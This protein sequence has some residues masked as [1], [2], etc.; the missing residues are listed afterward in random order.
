M[1]VIRENV[2]ALNAVLKVQIAPE[3][4]LGKVEK[5]LEDYR[6]RANIPGFRK[7]KV[8]MGLVKKQYGKGVLAEELNKTVNEALYNYL[9]AEK[10]EILGNP[11][12]KYDA[13]V[14]G[15]WDNP[16]DFEFQY[17]IGLTPEF[18]IKLSGRNKFD[19]VKVKTD[20][21]LVD[22]QI[23][24]LRRRYGKLIAGEEVTGTE[25][26]LGQ[27]VELDENG[28]IKEGG[29]MNSSTV[30]IEF[31]EDKATLKELKGKKVGDK[32][33][34]DPAKLAKGEADLAAMLGVTKE[35]LPNL[36][37]KFQFTINEI[38]K[39]EMA[40]LNQELFDKLFGEGEV[41]SE[42]EMRERISNDMNGMFDGDSDRLFTRKVYDHLIEKTEMALPDEFLKRWI[43]MSNQKEITDEQIEAEYDEYAKGLR[44][45]LIQGKLFKDNEVKINPD[46]AL[47]FT[48]SLLVSQYAQYGIPAPED[49][50]LT[51]SARKVLA[52]QEEANRV[53]DMLAE[54]KLTEL[55]KGIVKL[56][57]KEVSYDEFVKLAQGN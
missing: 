4:Y 48:K 12:P 29:V 1:N 32:L 54:R 9:N 37:D 13:E 40:E 14:K 19:Y 8:P 26:V 51:E 16:S 42:A 44:W 43:K 50:E 36:N 38:R 45:Q 52:N 49:N 55:F 27:F 41:K 5:A 35:D 24:D 23:D 3:D 31:V 47:E 22:Q 17:E 39:M 18:E 56:N 11:I 33:V 10:V 7:G 34:V 2:D 57:E 21:K 25:L 46:E 53:Y 6:K 30:S 28:E 15:D 20:D